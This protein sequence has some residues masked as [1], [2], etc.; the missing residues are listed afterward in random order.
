M[1]KRRKPIPK[2]QQEIFSGKKKSINRGNQIKRDDN[3]SNFY[4]GLYDIDESIQY[5]FD[6]VIKP[7]VTEGEELVRVPVLFGSPERWKSVQKSGYSRD[8]NGKRIIPL[9]MYRRSSVSK[10]N[11]FASKIDANNPQLMYDIFRRKYNKNNRYDKF[12]VLH[13]R[14]PSQESY[15]IVVPDYVT[16]SYDCIIWT[17]YV[18]HMNKLIESINY[19]AGSYWG[20]PEKYKFKANISDYSITTDT[21]QGAD[22]MVRAAF[23]IQMNGYIIPDALNKELSQSSIKSYSTSKI[24]MELKEI[25]NIK[26]IPRKN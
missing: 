8:V 2:T 17:D 5:Y 9:I 23:S 3:V 13:D 7:S 15:N 19:A 16:I 26:D 4:M 22:R 10:N 20:D 11:E 18:E 25:D 24:I 6:N 14:N 21:P 12:N 1:A